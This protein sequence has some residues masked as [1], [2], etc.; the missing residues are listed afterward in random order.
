MYCARRTLSDFASPF[1][2]P[3]DYFANMKL[4]DLNGKASP[5]PA[6]LHSHLPGCDPF[7]R[8]VD[9]AA[10]GRIPACLRVASYGNATSVQAYTLKVSD[11]NE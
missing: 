3:A 11:L 5:N 2:F 6:M 4:L 9:T 7:S 1:R 10:A 8:Y